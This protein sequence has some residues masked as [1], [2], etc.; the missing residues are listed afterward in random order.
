MLEWPEGIS[1]YRQHN[2]KESHDKKTNE[3][4]EC[5]LL[6]ALVM[7]AASAAL[8]CLAG[9]RGRS[10]GDWDA[11]PLTFGRTFGGFSR[12]SVLPRLDP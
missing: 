12:L 9:Q 11:T 2:G 1:R 3:L 7:T 8:I 5:I 4:A 10:P 6:P